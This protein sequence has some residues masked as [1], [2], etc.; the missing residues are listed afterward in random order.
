ME[1]PLTE[2]NRLFNFLE[3]QNIWTNRIQCIKKTSLKKLSESTVTENY[4][5]FL[6]FDDESREIIASATNILKASTPGANFACL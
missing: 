1:K 2:L 3:L 5:Q 6:Q 4:D